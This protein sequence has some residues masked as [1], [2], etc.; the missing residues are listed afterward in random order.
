MAII[1]SY[2]TV[3][4]TSSD[5]VLVV[6]T[7]EDGNP[8]KTAT[9]GSVNALATAPDIS[10]ATVLI[11]NAQLLTLGTVPITILPS[12]TNAYYQIIAASFTNTGS[13]STNYVW[14]SSKGVLYG[15]LKTNQRLEVPTTSLPSG[16]IAITTPYMGTPIAGTSRVG[17]AI[18]FSTDDGSD[19][20]YFGGTPNG[21]TTINLTYRLI[22]I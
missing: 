22:Q 18:S 16:E 1:N 15:F 19:P 5:L 14:G 8:T 7:S 10:T 4:P 11:T 13:G 9:V 6:D 20:S 17:S 2:P 3:T 12:V 21:T